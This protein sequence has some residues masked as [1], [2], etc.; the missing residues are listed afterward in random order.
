MRCDFAENYLFISQAESQGFHLENARA[1]VS[2]F[3][4]NLRESRLEDA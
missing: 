1:T 2:F 4:T 3:A